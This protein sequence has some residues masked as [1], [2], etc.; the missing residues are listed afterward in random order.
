MMYNVLGRVL[1]AWVSDYFAVKWWNHPMC[2]SL[3][4]AKYANFMFR[5]HSV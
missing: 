3:A 1:T 2:I 4:I 5:L